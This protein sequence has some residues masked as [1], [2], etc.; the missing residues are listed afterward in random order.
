MQFKHI[1]GKNKDHDNASWM[2]GGYSI[3]GFLIKPESCKSIQVF[4]PVKKQLINKKKLIL[5][6]ASTHR[7]QLSYSKRSRGH[8][9]Y[10]KGTIYTY[11]LC[12]STEKTNKI[13]T[14]FLTNVD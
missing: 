13:G 8:S 9:N 7:D 2:L 6:K 12:M 1:C 11:K 5:K 4:C 14:N 10:E 3:R